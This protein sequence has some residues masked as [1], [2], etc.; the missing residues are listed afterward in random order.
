MLNIIYRKMKLKKI[1]KIE[2]T[3]KVFPNYSKIN[4]DKL[5]KL[6]LNKEILE[7]CK[8]VLQE[9]KKKDLSLFFNNINDLKLSSKKDMSD[10]II[11]A[12][13]PGEN[14]IIFDE[15]NKYAIYHELFHI[16]S[17]FVIKN[18]YFSGFS[19]GHYTNSLLKKGDNY[20]DGI[21][22]GYTQLLTER[23]FDNIDK[24]RNH[25]IFE[26][27]VAENIEKIIGKKKMTSLY[28]NADLNGLINELNNYNSNQKVLEFIKR[29]DFIHNNFY[30]EII[31][32]N[33]K[34]LIQ[35]SITFIC[36]FLLKIYINYLN[37]E[38]IKNKITQEEYIIKLNNYINS[39]FDTIMVEHNQ[40]ILL[41][42][43]SIVKV[44]TQSSI[45]R[46]I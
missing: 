11:G 18:K 32:N 9:F 35:E 27:K 14:I 10:K 44:L 2:N 4:Y 13:L 34:Q 33:K 8:I 7:F 39:I 29:L 40:Y 16:I 3:P 41:S 30:N 31:S 43:E 19:Q 12:A 6:E 38:Y 37:E 21:N 25:Y 45:L 23:Y 15:N 20:G 36:E 22:E 1:K 42:T 28:L 5:K 24:I 17:S 46:K 26:V